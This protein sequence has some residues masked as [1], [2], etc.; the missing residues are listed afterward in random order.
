MAL[1]H[2]SQG[3]KSRGVVSACHTGTHSNSS[4]TPFV[5]FRRLVAMV[6]CPRH[7]CVRR[8]FVLHGEKQRLHQRAE[9]QPPH[10]IHRIFPAPL[11]TEAADTRIFIGLEGRGNTSLSHRLGRLHMFIHAVYPPLRHTLHRQACRT[12]AARRAGIAV[13]RY[14]CSVTSRRAAVHLPTSCSGPRVQAYAEASTPE[15]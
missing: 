7:P 13:S 8:V 10:R 15:R 9:R 3:R 1:P 6:A 2:A 11:M 12:E 14:Q 4:A 5:T